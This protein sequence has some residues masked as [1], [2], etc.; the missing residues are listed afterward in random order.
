VRIPA[1]LWRGPERS[2]PVWK[3]VY[4]ILVV[5]VSIPGVFASKPARISSRIK[6]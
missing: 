3:A 5:N 6:F 1:V 4:R 2:E